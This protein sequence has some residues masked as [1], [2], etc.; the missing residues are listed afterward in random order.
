MDDVVQRIVQKLYGD[1]DNWG[2]KFRVWHIPQVPGKSFKVEVPNF[3]TA[4]LI[5]E[6]LAQYDLFQYHNRIKGDYANASGI[7]YWD[8]T[9]GEWYNIDESEYDEWEGK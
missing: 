1:D 5:M 7:E 8:E 3:I 9:D 6:V 4:Q 2:K